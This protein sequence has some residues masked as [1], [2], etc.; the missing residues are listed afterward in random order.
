MNKKPRRFTVDMYD[1]RVPVIG[2]VVRHFN[3]RGDILG[4]YRLLDVRRV[5]VRVSRGETARF[6]LFMERLPGFPKQA[7]RILSVYDHPPRPKPDRFSPLL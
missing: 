5:K 2:D 1:D 3:F 4:F 6:T 7:L